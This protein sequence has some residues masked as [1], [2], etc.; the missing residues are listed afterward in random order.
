META[1][2]M[3]IGGG[4]SERE[5]H[6]PG[7]PEALAGGVHQPLRSARGPFAGGVRQREMQKPGLMYGEFHR[8]DSFGCLILQGEKRGKEDGEG[9]Y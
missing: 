3:A 4:G 7:S 2:E 1:E 6:V 8:R 9:F 5:T